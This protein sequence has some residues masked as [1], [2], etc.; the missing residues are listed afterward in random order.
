MKLNRH[1]VVDGGLERIFQMKQNVLRLFL[2]GASPQTP[3]LAPLDT[4]KSTIAYLAQSF[5]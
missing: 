1:Y 5:F 3:G 4:E 2:M